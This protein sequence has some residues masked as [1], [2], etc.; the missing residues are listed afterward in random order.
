M[1]GINSYNKTL[2][3]EANRKLPKATKD[4]IAKVRKN[5]KIRDTLF[6][7]MTRDFGDKWYRNLTSMIS[8]IPSHWMEY[9]FPENIKFAPS[10][11]SKDAFNYKLSLV[12]KYNNCL[13]LVLS[14][15][16]NSV[17][18]IKIFSPLENDM[19]YRFEFEKE[20]IEAYIHEHDIELAILK[21][22]S[23]FEKEYTK[24]AD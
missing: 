3:V 18:E 14:V 10:I 13:E 23:V 20:K 11:S 1:F 19:P 24:L 2:T 17:F 6:E 5:Q 4:L 21:A 16:D 15:K 7:E 12:F 9:L 8:C 22:F